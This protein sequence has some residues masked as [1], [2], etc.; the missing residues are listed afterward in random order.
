MFNNQLFGEVK[1]LDLDANFS[2]INTPTLTDFKLDT[3]SKN[4]QNFSSMHT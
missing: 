3:T 2:G 4:M 1:K